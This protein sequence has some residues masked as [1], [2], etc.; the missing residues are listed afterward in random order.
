MGCVRLRAY[1]AMHAPRRVLPWKG[2]VCQTSGTQ[3]FRSPTPCRCRS[4]H[5]RGCWEGTHTT[6]RVLATHS[7]MQFFPLPF[8]IVFYAC[9]LCKR[10]F[11]NGL[12]WKLTLNS[13][14]FIWGITKNSLLQFATILECN[15]IQIVTFLAQNWNRTS[16]AWT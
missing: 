8:Q 4:P 1:N 14:G 11:W 7:F 13:E 2:W 15:K 9:L 16:W 3:G 5:H 6:S 12:N 10:F